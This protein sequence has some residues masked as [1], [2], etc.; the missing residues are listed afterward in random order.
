MKPA[1]LAL[2]VLVVCSS[3]TADAAF[4]RTAGHVIFVSDRD[5]D[6]D[7][8]GISGDGRRVAALT[9]NNLPEASVVISPA[10]NWIGETRGS[11]AG[12]L[13]SADGRHERRLPGRPDAF[14]ADGRLVALETGVSPNWGIATIPP[15]G[16]G[17]RRF[18]PGVPIE[19]SPARRL[20]SFWEE[21]TA[22]IGL[23][24]LPTGRRTIVIDETP[25]DIGYVWW[26]PS[27]SKV[28]WV[29]RVSENFVLADELVVR[30][31][32][33]PDL[34]PSVLRHGVAPER[35][36][37]LD[38][39]RLLVDNAV[40]RTDGTIERTFGTYPREVQASPGKNVVAYYEWNDPEN[41]T[42]PKLFVAT[43]DGSDTHVVKLAGSP[44][45][46]AWSP[47]GRFVAV[48]VRTR[49]TNALVFVDV[50][51]RRVMRTVRL[52]S[53]VDELRWSPDD[54]RV[55]ADKLGAREVI[56]A[57]RTG[58]IRRVPTYGSTRV[59]GWMKGPLA[60]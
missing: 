18:G 53:R 7:I 37:W 15:D 16:R 57:S 25:L 22:G 41:R 19:F 10:G 4:T 9:R 45:G 1:L 12:V 21:G 31:R 47:S 39:S 48:A 36:S 28:A 17:L 46:L 3:A 24:D 35:V 49:S 44:S 14:S 27:W 6:N 33:R 56:I 38:E 43:I 58:W 51:R 8:Y 50:T 26:S 23:I 59:I 11:S 54:V 52:P 29:R 42:D 55:L 13:I 5:G 32:T 20:L 2:F 34:R 60:R 30:A 40:I